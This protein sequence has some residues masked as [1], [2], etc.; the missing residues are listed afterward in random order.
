[1][2]TCATVAGFA[3]LPMAARVPSR[4]CSPSV[5]RCART[6]PGI[7]APTRLR[8]R[9]ASRSAWTTRPPPSADEESTEV[10]LGD[11]VTADQEMPLPDSAQCTI[12]WLYRLINETQ[13]EMVSLGYAND[14]NAD[15]ES[16]DA[17]GKA[18][19]LAVKV[20]ETLP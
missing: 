13:G 9:A 1:M 8:T 5:D 12:T 19:A 14:D 10:D 17:C 16:D 11:G 3:P 15:S 4:S 6:R 2:S 7:V 20:V 18:K